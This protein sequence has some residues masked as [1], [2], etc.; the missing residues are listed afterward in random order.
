MDKPKRTPA[1]L[2]RDQLL[3]FASDLPGIIQEVDAE[4]P[5]TERSPILWHVAWELMRVP[6]DT[7]YTN[8]EAFGTVLA[9]HCILRSPEVLLEATRRYYDRL[10]ASLGAEDQAAL[11]LLSDRR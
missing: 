8:A 7:N 1:Q 2:Q 4:G 11:A 5:I 10:C 3:A 6:A 9:L